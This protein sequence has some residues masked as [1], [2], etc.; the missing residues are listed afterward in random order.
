MTNPKKPFYNTPHIDPTWYFVTAQPTS[1]RYFVTRILINKETD[2][3][4][5]RFAGFFVNNKC[6][7]RQIKVRNHIGSVGVIK[8]DKKARAE[9]FLL[10]YQV[11]RFIWPQLNNSLVGFPPLI[12]R[13]FRQ[14]NVWLN[15]HHWFVYRLKCIYHKSVI[16]TDWQIGSTGLD[17]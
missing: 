2:V 3:T 17:K 16:L 9:Q 13:I 15:I 11:V 1:T 5:L 4:Y 14:N 10:C 12:W 6:F 7:A 8:I